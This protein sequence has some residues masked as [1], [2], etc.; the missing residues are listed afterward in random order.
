LADK[1]E[2]DET[3]RIAEQ[4]DRLGTEGLKKAEKVLAD[5]KAEHD[6]PIPPDLLTQF[7]IPSVK[8]ISW[9]PVQ[10]L[11]QPGTGRAARAIT[12]PSELAKRI[13][14]DGSPLPFFVQY[15]HVEVRDR[16]STESAS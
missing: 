15:D 4:V 14:A 13:E 6:H 3:K 2:N 9:I 16:V 12:T 10:S 8:S 1:L 5:A 11:Q 7:P